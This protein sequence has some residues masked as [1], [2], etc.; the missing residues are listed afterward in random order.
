MKLF[1]GMLDGLTFSLMDDVPEGMTYLR[2]Q[3]PEGLL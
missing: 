3:T 2:E 1:C